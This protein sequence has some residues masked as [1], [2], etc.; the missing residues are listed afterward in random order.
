MGRRPALITDRVD[1]TPSTN[2]VRWR[3]NAGSCRCP[4]LWLH[5][6]WWLI[7]G[8]RS[9]P[10]HSPRWP[11]PA[12]NVSAHPILFVIHLALATRYNFPVDSEE[13]K[14]YGSETSATNHRL[15]VNFCPRHSTSG[16][17][18]GTANQPRMIEKICDSR[19]G[20]HV[21]NCFS[22]Y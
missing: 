21:S 10:L 19:V 16:V 18:R 22:H 15:D 14:Q 4:A 3:L 17:V 13:I 20:R 7:C 2:H 1:L 12:S 9:K 6:W 11:S 8:C 5:P